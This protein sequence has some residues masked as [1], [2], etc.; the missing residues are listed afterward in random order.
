MKFDCTIIGAGLS[1]ITVLVNLLE[2]L[3]KKKLKKKFKFCIIDKD[4]ELIAGG[5]AY[6]IKCS[7][8]GFFNNPI[9]LSHP[10][11]VKWIRR[12]NNLF[13]VKEYL[14]INGSEVEKEWAKKK[15]NTKSP[16]FSEEYLPRVIVNF[17]LKSILL[18]T[19]K[20][21]N[22]K[23]SIYWIKSDIHKIKK[24]KN[25][26]K[27]FSSKKFI[28]LYSKDFITFYK[29]ETIKSIESRIISFSLGIPSPKKF[30]NKKFLSKM[31][32]W[33]FYAEGSTE[34]LKKLIFNIKKKKLIKIFFIGYKAGLLEPLMEIKYLLKT[35]G[36][37][38]K[39]ITLSN[40]LKSLEPA[41]KSKNFRKL[42]FKKLDEKNIKNI[43]TGKELFDLFI[44]EIDEAKKGGFNKYD[45]WTKVLSE[46][47]LDKILN[48]FSKNQLLKYNKVYHSKIRSLTRFTFPDVVFLKNKLVKKKIINIAR[49]K[50]VKIE[51]KNKNL[52]ILI[53][54]DQKFKNIVADI[55]VNASGPQ[56][57]KDLIKNNSLVNSLKNICNIS[58]KGFDFNN[59]F[60]IAKNIFSPGYLS[61]GFNPA[62]KTLF[63][64]IIENSNKVG[65]VIGNEIQ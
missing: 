42:K 54:K 27:I 19:I 52:H 39:I 5:V 40:S 62:R 43:K 51:N 18:K 63:K 7:T 26:Y 38:I 14:R 56:K 61:A 22:Q 47:T 2:T 28:K 6:S 16:N 11:F 59:N 37:K 29:Q 46:K 4:P 17:W 20:K 45:V 24:E 41:I 60:E 23:I 1:G 55:V 8:S 25:H 65:K 58:E 21:T 12:K 36:H 44:K 33:D 34:K 13:K 53:K 3:N 50:I 64:A 32:L 57:M 48:N 10:D 31:Y 15:I 30:H 49:G 9:R 35:L